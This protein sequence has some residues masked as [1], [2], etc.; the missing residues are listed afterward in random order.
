MDVHRRHSAWAYGIAILLAIGFTLAPNTISDP[1][2]W[3]HL[4]TGEWILQN[5]SLP[6]AD[7]FS[8]YG[9][10]RPWVAYTWAVRCALVRG[11]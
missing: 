11:F 6:S 10:D 2:L 4:R 5:A 3:W 7:P 1:D 9:A 8:T